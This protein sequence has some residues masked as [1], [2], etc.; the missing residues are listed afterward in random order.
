MKPYRNAALLATAK[1]QPCMLQIP[2]VCNG[3]ESTVVACHSNMS[4][5]GKGVGLRSHDW[6]IAYGCANCHYEIDHGHKMSRAERED[7]W[8]RGNA[9]TLAYLF[10]EGI[11]R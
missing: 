8:F 5:H 10:D 2:G 7:A 9:R 3:D 11:L 6:A 1:G 4:L